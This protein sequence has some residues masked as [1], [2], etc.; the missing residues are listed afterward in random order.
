[1][2]SPV[3]TEPARSQGVRLPASAP[4]KARVMRILEHNRLSCEYQPIVRTETRSVEGYEALARFKVDD[5]VEAPKDVF[6]ALH[7]DRT[8][9]FLLE[10]RVKRLQLAHRPKTGRLF[11][12]LDPHVC[13]EPYQ[14]EHWLAVFAHHPD[15]VVEILESTNSAHLSTIHEFVKSLHRSG[16]QVALDD[17]GGPQNLLSFDLLDEVQ[18]LKLDRLWLS[19]VRGTPAYTALL[20]GLT[21][22]AKQRKIDCILE[23]VETEE[24][25]ELAK[26]LNV[27]FVQGF[28]FRSE[29]ITAE[30]SS[31]LISKEEA[32]ARTIKTAP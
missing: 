27:D 11:L 17:I 32:E 7:G 9:F 4:L 25:F 23:G 6:D 13:E 8:L 12:N 24:D 15:V 22:F 26:S 3:G 29:F 30:S 19:R 14:L 1:M 21:A 28:L 18:V 5:K 10:A 16:I 20:Q 31:P 2:S